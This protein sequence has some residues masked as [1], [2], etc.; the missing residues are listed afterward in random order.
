MNESIILKSIL[1]MTYLILSIFPF[2]ISFITFPIIQ[3]LVCLLLKL[4]II[5]IKIISK[6]KIL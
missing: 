1:P 5:I 4:K 6:I 2:L 3:S